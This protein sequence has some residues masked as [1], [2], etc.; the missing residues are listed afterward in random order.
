MKY[1]KQ[2][3]DYAVKDYKRIL[4]EYSYK[5]FILIFDSSDDKAFFSIAPLSQALHELHSDLYV[6]SKDKDKSI[7]FD[8][9]QKIWSVSKNIINNKRD[10]DTK[11]LSNFI[12]V[13]IKK[14]GQDKFK[15]L[16][17]VPDLII[18]SKKN[19]FLAGKIKLP[20]KYKW[21][22][23]YKAS[24]L[25]ISA[26][27]IWKYVFNL[28][29][30]EIV[31]IDL[32]L[33]PPES[34]LKLPLEDYLD[35]YAIVKEM[36][37]AAKSF[38]ALPMIKGYTA[39]VSPIEPAEHIA[40]LLNTLYGCEHCKQINE[41][42]FKQYAELSKSLNLKTLVPPSGHFM[43]SSQ[44]FR[45]RHLFGEI[46]GYPTLNRKSRWDSPAKMFLKK[47]DEPQ[48]QEE[49]RKPLTRVALTE[50]LP[51]DVFIETTNIDYS[52]LRKITHNLKQ[53][54]KGCALINVVSKDK[55]DGYSTNLII[56]ITNRK[57]FPDDSDV[58]ELFDKDVYKETNNY[59]GKYTNIPG[60]EVFITPEDM[61][62]TFV[63]DVVIHTDRSVKLTQEKPIIVEIN[64]GR[65][66]II[67]TNKELFS[68]IEEVKKEHLK[69]LLEKEKY[70]SLPQKII[71]QQK[72]NFDRIGEFAINTHPTAKLCDYLV[73]NEKIARMIHI[74]LGNGFE[75]DRQTVY[76]FD[77]V[78]DAAKQKLDIF[79]VKPDGT[80]VWILKKGRT[81]F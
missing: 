20:Y 47:E 69:V 49:T 57:L 38:G 65:Y 36:S 58:T 48:A 59:F 13:I 50:T 2:L 7:E 16:F 46:I 75:K 29:K 71:D 42:I 19:N 78:I 53:Q 56:D 9:L 66:Q 4:A 31:Q 28:K 27:K 77:I 26:K 73:V 17:R 54:L 76:H 45:G 14:S 72:D 51:I 70:K 43:I 21:F 68:N 3:F 25:K 5:S 55:V 8:I 23:L 79:G 6:I 80:E 10:K 11:L 39:R 22:K 64:N 24:K 18:E 34:I 15:K 62:G 74:A 52:N 35:S 40:D 32:P 30:N 1:K 60:G 33:I 67:E 41:P 37:K 81:V 44:G 12:N 63:G 61:Q